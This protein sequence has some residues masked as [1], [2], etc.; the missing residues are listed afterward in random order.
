MGRRKKNLYNPSTSLRAGR[1][2]R[3]SQGRAEVPALATLPQ[4]ICNLFLLMFASAYTSFHESGNGSANTAAEV[5]G[6]QHVSSAAGA[7]CAE[8]A[9][10]ARCLRGDAD[11]WGQVFV[12]PAAGGGFGRNGGGDFSADRADARSGGATGADGDSGGGAEQH[13]ERR[14]TDEGDEPGA[15]WGL[16][17]AVCV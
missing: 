17:A 6:V 5:L 8:L 16:P 13:F 12:L 15:E 11:G 3:G 2:H 7:D 14:G 9:G 1:G 10:G 4:D